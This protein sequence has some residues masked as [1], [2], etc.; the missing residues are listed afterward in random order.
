MRKVISLLCCL[1]LL[2][3]QLLQAQSLTDYLDEL[4]NSIRQ[5]ETLLDSLQTNSQMQEQLLASLK[6]SLEKQRLLSANFG[7]LLDDSIQYSKRLEKER[8]IWRIITGALAVSLT[9]TL[10]VA[11]TNK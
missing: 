10:I 8:N 9:T 5:Q 1:A 3:G 7:S 6:E 4:E 2:S 11:G